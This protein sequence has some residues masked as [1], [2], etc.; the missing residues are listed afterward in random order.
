MGTEF[1]ALVFSPTHS[2][3]PPRGWVASLSSSHGLGFPELHFFDAQEDVW[4]MTRRTIC[5]CIIVRTHFRSA[6][7]VPRTLLGLP[8]RILTKD[9]EAKAVFVTVFQAWGI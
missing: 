8:D 6:H 2:H 1:A 5:Y 7:C 9:K 3:F 4:A